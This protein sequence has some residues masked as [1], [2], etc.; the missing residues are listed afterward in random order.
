MWPVSRLL[1]RR[2]AASAEQGRVDS[3]DEVA[4]LEP[5]GVPRRGYDGEAASAQRRTDAD[6]M[7]QAAEAQPRALGRDSALFEQQNEAVIAKTLSGAVGG[8]AA[9]PKAI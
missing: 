6:A 2:P 7:P 3:E 1:Q 4:A 9:L 8:S 5:T